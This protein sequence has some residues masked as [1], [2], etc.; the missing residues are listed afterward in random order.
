MELNKRK[1]REDKQV[2]AERSCTGGAKWTN[3]DTNSFEIMSTHNAVVGFFIG[4]GPAMGGI[5]YH[6]DEVS[7]RAGRGGLGLN[8]RVDLARETSRQAWVCTHCACTH[9]RSQEPRKS[10][11]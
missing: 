7:I 6:C 3:D 10:G 5:E 8:C 4:Y 1:D 11:C 2:D 9:A